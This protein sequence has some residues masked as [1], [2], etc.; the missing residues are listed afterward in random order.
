MPEESRIQRGDQ[1]RPD[2]TSIHVQHAIEGKQE[3]AAWVISHFQPFVEAQVRVRLGSS[4]RQ[5]DVEDLANELW[6]VTLRRLPELQPREGRYAPVLVKFL[7]T[8]ALQLCNNFLRSRIRRG[9]KR[10]NSPSDGGSAELD[11]FARS[12]RGIVAR[13]ALSDVRAQVERCLA[14]LTPAKRD[15]LVLRIME[16]RTN[17]EIAE[18]LGLEPNTVAVRYKRA[19][20]D[21]RKCLPADVFEDLWD[22]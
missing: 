13:A 10:G 11:D 14:E 15:V 2:P 17:Q 20:E 7:G 18:I 5:E 16:Q 8:T 3:S 6:L 21:V 4:G 1:A 12:T 9:M 19:L 22:A